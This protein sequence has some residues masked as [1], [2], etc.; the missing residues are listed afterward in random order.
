MI[1][2]NETEAKL[3]ELVM[4]GAT[5][6]EMVYEMH[7][8]T[9]SILYA[10][11]KLAKRGLITGK[12]NG[13]ETT[14]TVVNPAAEYQIIMNRYR[15]P[16]PKSRFAL[17]RIMIKRMDID[18]LRF[19]FYQKDISDIAYIAR[20]LGMEESYVSVIIDRFRRVSA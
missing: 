1:Q 8:E 14:Y 5:R 3:Y 19:I 11:S 18:K 2:L 9:G 16:L 17:L 12:K 7:M 20:K 15:V 4:A 13:R 10:L 6:D